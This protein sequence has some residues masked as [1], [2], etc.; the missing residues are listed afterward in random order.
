MELGL[1][2]LNVREGERVLEIGFGTGHALLKLAKAA[3]E[4][5]KVCGVDISDGM[6][7]ISRERLA[8]KGL[9]KRVKLLRADATLLPYPL[10]YFDA[11]FMAFTLELFDTPQIP[12][13]LAECRRVLCKGGR[14]GVVAMSKK[15]GGSTLRLYE[16]AHR[17]LPNYVDCRPIY[18]RE[19]IEAAGFRILE[20]ERMSMWRLPVEIVLAAKNH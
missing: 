10:N 12:E 4:K 20:A 17:R 9:A 19:A 16:W 2:K 13:I 14:L 8:R 18:V 1:E 11:L 6:L 15:G 7:K 3:G 5:G